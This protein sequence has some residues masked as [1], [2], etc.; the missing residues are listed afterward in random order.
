M[1]GFQLDFNDTFAGGIED[2]TYEVVVNRANEDA[3]Q[4]G[5]EYAEL[6]LIIRN[7]VDQKHKNQHIF[8]KVWKSK[9]TNKY[10]FQMFN[11]IGKALRLENGRSYNGIGDLLSDFEFKGARVTVKNETSEYNG[12]TYDNLDVKSWA[13]SKFPNIQHQYKDPAPKNDTPTETITDD[14]LPF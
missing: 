9:K 2:G 11:T 14:D 8:A 6:D 7:D 10:N 5:A 4:G 13:Q 3:T 1:T 12:K